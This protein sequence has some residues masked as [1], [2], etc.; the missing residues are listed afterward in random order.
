MKLFNISI[1]WANLCCIVEL[2]CI[3]FLNQIRIQL[4]IEYLSFTDINCNY[5]N[6]NV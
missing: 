3:F 5:I 2:Y 6:C 4:N 1:M